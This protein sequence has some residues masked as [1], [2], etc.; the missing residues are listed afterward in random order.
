VRRLIA[1]SA[2][3]LAA[4]AS[5]GIGG[6][7]F[8]SDCTGASCTANP[9]G[10]VVGH[11]VIPTT[12]SLSLDTYAFTINTDAGQTGSTTV[13]ATVNTN[14][15]I[16]FDLDTWLVDSSNPD[17]LGD[18]EYYDGAAFTDGGANSI[19]DSVWSDNATAYPATPMGKQPQQLTAQSI[20][21]TTANGPVSQTY[22]QNLAVAVP[23]TQAAA[24]YTGDV[25]FAAVAQ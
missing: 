2:V 9:T 15:A 3:A 23:G 4:L 6:T 18:G 12:I 16:G 14:D 21:P 8:A 17:G 24:T 22:A 10:P 20:D 7:A 11:V 25:D 13:N 19:P 1:G 5:A